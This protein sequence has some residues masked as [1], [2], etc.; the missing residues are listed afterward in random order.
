MSMDFIF[1]LLLLDFFGRGDADVCHSLLCLFVSGS[2]SQI[3]VSPP[4][5]TFFKKFLSLWIR[6]R[7]WRHTSY[8]LSFCSTVRFLGTIFAHNFLTA[9]PCVKIWRTV[10]W[11]KFVTSDHSHCESTVW[12]HKGSH[13]LHIFIRFW[14]WRS[15]RAGLIFNGFTALW[16][17]HIPLEHLWS[18]QSML[19]IGLLQ[20]IE[21]FNAGFPKFDTKL[22]CTSL[23]DIALF[24]F[25]DT[26]TQKLLHKKPHLN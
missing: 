23:L 3:H 24:H 26:H 19:P 12:P 2:Y 6:S 21:S 25:R 22:V 10:V 14:S 8:R 5:I 1:D 4:V 13:F 15:S 16:K 11:F 18:R 7:R 20:F 17:C 9:N